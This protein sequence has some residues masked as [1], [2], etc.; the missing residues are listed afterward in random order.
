MPASRT[1]TVVVEG[2]V[3]EPALAK[4]QRL[5]STAASLPPPTIDGTRD[6][7]PH[8]AIAHPLLV[9]CPPLGRWLHAHTEPIVPTW[10]ARRQHTLDRVIPAASLGEWHR[11]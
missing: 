9:L 6:G 4:L 8:N 7:F 3:D 2:K 10:R 5:A 1:L 11:W